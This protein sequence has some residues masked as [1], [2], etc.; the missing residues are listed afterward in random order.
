MLGHKVREFRSF[1]AICLEDLVP[2][3]NFYRQVERSI[4]LSF[5]RDLADEFYSSIGRVILNRSISF[6]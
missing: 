6:H 5:V 4:D 2:E 3:E 1:T